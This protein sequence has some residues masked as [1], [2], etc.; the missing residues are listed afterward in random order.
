K[1]QLNGPPDELPCLA[2]SPDGKQLAVA[3]SES[4]VHLRDLAT[5]KRLTFGPGHQERLVSVACSPDGRLIATAAWDGAVYLWDARTG[6]ELRGIQADRDGRKRWY[7]FP[8]RLDHV[9]FSPDGKLL[10]VTRGDETVLILDVA[11]GK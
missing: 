3:S 9:A 11:S 2:F 7:S 8:A 4:A 6:K 1:G 10:G 5:G